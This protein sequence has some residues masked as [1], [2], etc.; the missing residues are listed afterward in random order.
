MPHN[1]RGPQNTLRHDTIPKA[2]ERFPGPMPLCDGRSVEQEREEPTGT[3]QIPSEQTASCHMAAVETD[4]GVDLAVPIDLF[5]SYP[6][7]F[8]RDPWFEYFGENETREAFA[9]LLAKPG[10]VMRCG[11]DR[12][13]EAVG[14]TIA[15]P[16]REEPEIL[17][18][19][20]DLES[21]GAY[22]SEL[23]VDPAHQARGYGRSLLCDAESNLQDLGY[24]HVVLRTMANCNWLVVFYL[25]R[26]YE[27]IG[28]Q[29]APLNRKIDG[30]VTKVPCKRVLLVKLLETG[31]E[32]RSDRQQGGR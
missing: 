11:F 18:Y 25:K 6:A 13:G 8:G 24:S 5:A 2:G 32:Q 12:D 3:D 16:L 17:K 9:K 23:W 29:D 1:E 27:I 22:L 15:Y 14:A 20:R 28:C 31:C 10:A 4:G 21:T 26:G 7:A 30:C 19:R